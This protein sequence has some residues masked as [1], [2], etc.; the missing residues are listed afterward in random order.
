M[1]ALA[2]GDCSGMCLVML[3]LL[4]VEGHAQHLNQFGGLII[5]KL[6]QGEWYMQHLVLGDIEAFVWKYKIFTKLAHWANSV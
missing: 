3:Q 6:Q 5:F 1:T 2:G 4:Q